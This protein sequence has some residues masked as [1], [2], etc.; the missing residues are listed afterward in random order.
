MAYQVHTVTILKED[1]EKA[2][3]ILEKHWMMGDIDAIT[4]NEEKGTDGC[5]KIIY[6]ISPYICEDLGV[7]ENEFKQEGIRVL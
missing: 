2:D 6:W 3:A 4:T 1:R 5:I 7:I